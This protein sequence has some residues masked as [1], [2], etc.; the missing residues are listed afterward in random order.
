MCLARIARYERDVVGPVALARAL[1]SASGKGGQKE[2]RTW[3][4]WLQ[5]AASWKFPLTRE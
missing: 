3:G 5:V 4:L 2:D 1:V